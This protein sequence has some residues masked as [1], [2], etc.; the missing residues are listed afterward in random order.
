MIKFYVGKPRSGKT[1]ALVQDIHDNFMN[2]KS[3]DY[4]NINIYILI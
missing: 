1:Y 2:P 4:K 3:K